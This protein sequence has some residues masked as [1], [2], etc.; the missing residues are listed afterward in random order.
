ME[1]H[2]VF[3]KYTR[4]WLHEVTGYS[5]LYLCRV[6]NGRVPLTTAFVDRVTFKLGEPTDQLFNLEAAG[7]AAGG[8]PQRD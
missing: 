6:A 1:Q 5:K 4:A 8:N 2:Q 3:R 7:S